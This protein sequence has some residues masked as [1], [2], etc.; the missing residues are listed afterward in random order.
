MSTFDSCLF[1]PSFDDKVLAAER[2][3]GS[4]ATPGQM[5]RIC[6]STCSWA[7]RQGG[8]SGAPSAFGNTALPWR[9]T[10]RNDVLLREKLIGRGAN[11]YPGAAGLSGFRVLIWQ[12]I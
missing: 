4:G 1:G 11:L 12:P 7:T 8:S 10:D 2:Y 5:R 3:I 9:R 6:E